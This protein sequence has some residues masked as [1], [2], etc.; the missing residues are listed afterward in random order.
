MIVFLITCLTMDNNIIV[1]MVLFTHK[2]TAKCA[3]LGFVWQGASDAWWGK[4][5]DPSHLELTSEISSVCF[6]THPPTRSCRNHLPT[7]PRPV[8]LTLLA[9]YCFQII[10]KIFHFHTANLHE[11]EILLQKYRS[12]GVLRKS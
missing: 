11:S 4:N 6:Y 8:C 9:N 12:L 7:T 1:L 5:K 3:G 10:V 2:S